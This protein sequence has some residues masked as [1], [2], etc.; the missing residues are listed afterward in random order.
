M[1]RTLRCGSGCRRNGREDR[2]AAALEFGLIL[3]IL[4]MLVFGVIAFG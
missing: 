3:P 1:R 4:V 2:G